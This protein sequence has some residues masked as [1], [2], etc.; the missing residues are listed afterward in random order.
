VITLGPPGDYTVP[1]GDPLRRF[2]SLLVCLLLVIQGW[3]GAAMTP[4]QHPNAEVVA[5]TDA[6]AG[7]CPGHTQAM[8]AGDT[9]APAV[10][11]D[12]GVA[13]VAG[14]LAGCDCRLC[15]MGTQGARSD[16]SLPSPEG[17][18]AVLHAPFLSIPGSSPTSPP[19]KPPR[20]PA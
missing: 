19:L 9:D 2:S 8:P 15:F 7:D 6:E 11:A 12:V 3:A 17:L 1:M 16:V 20:R 5:V 14:A 18:A 4:C 13:D 10:V